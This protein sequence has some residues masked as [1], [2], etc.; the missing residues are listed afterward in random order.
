M[1]EYI[2]QFINYLS[3]E[4]NYSANTLRAYGKDLAE[5]AEFLQSKNL[6]CDLNDIDDSHVRIFMGLLNTKNSKST[7][8]RKLAS[9]RAFFEYLQRDKIIKANP[10][11]LIPAPKKEK[12]LPV[13]L[14]VD[15]MF[16]LIDQGIYKGVKGLRD[17][18]ILELM[19]SSGI[20]VGELVNLKFDNLN[21]EKN[22]L[23]LLGKGNKERIVPVGKKAIESLLEY[24]QKREILKPGTDYIFINNRGTKISERSIGRIVKKFAEAA[25]LSKNISPHALRHSFATHLLGS[26]ADLRAI[27]DMLGHSSLSVTQK[28]THTSIERIMDVYDKTHPRS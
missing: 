18:A 27:Q 1:N 17:K 28:Y 2:S 16:R 22:E 6:A 15:E 19:Y 7:I 23:K 14:S 12:K 21:L 5:F 11:K 26:G 8:E 20:R 3:T 4:R 13:F 10:A 24:L 9:L 25:S